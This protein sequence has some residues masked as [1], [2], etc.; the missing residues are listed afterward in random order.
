MKRPLHF[1]TPREVR[2]SLTKIAN[3]TRSG[4]LSPQ[5]ANALVCCCNAILGSIRADE[6][7]RRIAELEKMLSELEDS[8][9]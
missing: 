3:E 8:R 4:E 7:E 2:Q 6:Q 1:S 9:R 5:V